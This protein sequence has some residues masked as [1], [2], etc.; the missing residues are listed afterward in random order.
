[1]S[2]SILYI[3]RARCRSSPRKLYTH[4]YIVLTVLITDIKFY[5]NE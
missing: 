4:T 1:M 5:L 3:L 2:K